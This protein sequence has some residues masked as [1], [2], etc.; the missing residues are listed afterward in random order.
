MNFIFA[1]AIAAHPV[2]HRTISRLR[3]PI[4]Y[5]KTA[6][7]RSGSDVRETAV[8]SWTRRRLKG[9]LG[10]VSFGTARRKLGLTQNHAC[11]EF[12]IVKSRPSDRK[13]RQRNHPSRDF[14][15][16][17]A[18]KL[19]RDRFFRNLPVL[20]V[21]DRD[22]KRLHWRV[23]VRRVAVADIVNEKWANGTRPGSRPAS[24]HWLG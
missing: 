12:G 2:C 20:A 18:Q 17:A 13:C 5:L 19:F 24:G 3:L 8:T 1:Y 22:V 9:A 10:G 7:M 16:R 14:I 21:E 15:S 23:V 11:D 4:A 6:T